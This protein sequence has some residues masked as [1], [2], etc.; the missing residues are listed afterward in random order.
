[1][2]E[3]FDLLKIMRHALCTVDAAAKGTGPTFDILDSS[4]DGE[5]VPVAPEEAP[6]EIITGICRW[7]ARRHGPL[8][9]ILFHDAHGK[10]SGALAGAKY[11]RDDAAHSG[12]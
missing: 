11:Q 2:A 3:I 12:E 1:M 8:V 5:A 7:T 9:D 4:G 6:A 10:E